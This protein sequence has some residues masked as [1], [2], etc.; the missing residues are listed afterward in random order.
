VNS[1]VIHTPHGTSLDVTFPV[2]TNLLPDGNFDQG[3]WEPHVGDCDAANPTL[4]APE[5]DATVLHHRGPGGS[6]VLK[7]VAGVDTACE[8]QKFALTTGTPLLSIRT[9]NL[10]G[11]GPRLCL[12]AVGPNTCIP[13][14]PVPDTSTWNTYVAT[15]TPPAGTTGLALFLYADG[16]GGGS[17]SVDEYA[18]VTVHNFS[19]N[20]IV[21]A[22]PTPKTRNRQR[23]R[24][25][26]ADSSYS[27][28]WNGPAGSRHVLVD[29]MT[30]GWLVPPGAP[31]A[32]SPG[33]RGTKM[34]AG[35]AVI[36]GVAVILLLS[37]VC[38]ILIID[39]TRRHRRSGV[40]G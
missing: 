11:T 2:T 14:P 23:V 37:F 17:T 21:L 27:S 6:N 35:A 24:L 18:D 40:P 8:S 3:L 16:P 9:R 20:P 28:T 31:A 38:L 4:A 13:L 39:R 15:A 29:G 26:A 30:N 33:Y 19:V 7:L 32:Q 34:V 36:S 22:T 25:V 5:L 10:S 1:S 12:Y